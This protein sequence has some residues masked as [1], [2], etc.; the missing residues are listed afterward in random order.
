MRVV[1][2]GWGRCGERPFSY[3]P[4]VGYQIADSSELEWE[5]RPPGAEGQKPRLA[6]DVTTAAG[7]QQ[8][9]GR[10]WRY[11]LERAAGAMRTRLRKRCSS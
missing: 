2:S 10:V 5:E 11:H 3:D 7:L 8:S 1:A 9:R 4:G 6:A